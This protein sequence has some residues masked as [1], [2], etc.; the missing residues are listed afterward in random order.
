MNYTLVDSEVTIGRQAG[1]VQTS[2]LRPLAG[3]S[4]NLFN[5]MAEFRMQSFAARLLWNYFGDRIS[6][7]GSLGLPDI[8]E[9]GRSSVDVVLSQRWDA[10]SLKVAFENLLDDPFLFSQ[11]GREQ[12]VFKLG[13]A[14]SF[15]ID[16]HP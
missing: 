16:L 9:E 10:F 13:R 14:V 15:G 11:A 8:I 4:K 7:V 3:T 12:R 5:A 1:Q 6:D 2:L